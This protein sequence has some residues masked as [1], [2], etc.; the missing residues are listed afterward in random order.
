MGPG[1]EGAVTTD[2][3]RFLR[4]LRP[5]ATLCGSVVLWW[6]LAT[7]A[8]EATDG[9]QREGLGTDRVI[10]TVDEV[11]QTAPRL[12]G[13]TARQT[14]DPARSSVAAE[15]I[16][17][18]RQHADPIRSVTRTIVRTTAAE[19]VVARVSHTVR[20]QVRPALQQ[21][22]A[23]LDATPVGGAVIPEAES[24]GDVALVGESSILQGQTTSNRS[25]GST[26]EMVAPRGGS[27]PSTSPDA[28]SPTALDGQAQAAASPSSGGDAEGPA[29]RSSG[30]TAA[31][32]AQ[33]GAPPG[34]GAGLRAAGLDHT[35][36]STRTAISS[37]ADRIAAGPAHRPASTPD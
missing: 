26:A 35:L 17:T 18:V 24:A 15:V 7:G 23:V 31:S 28:G 33:G 5:V 10:G 11:A 12:A 25:S 36:P 14:H 16:K 34:P 20:V 21:V 37:L 6:C 8:A 3:R 30:G 29:L 9:Q 19:P 13:N 27:I 1:S 22:R 2:I 32:S 4:A